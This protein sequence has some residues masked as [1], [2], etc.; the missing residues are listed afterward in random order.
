MRANA[1]KACFGLEA[2][3]NV[4]GVSA[5]DQQSTAK[6][7]QIAIELSQGVVYEEQMSL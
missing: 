2:A 3:D 1:V 5:P 4:D 6:P 7:A